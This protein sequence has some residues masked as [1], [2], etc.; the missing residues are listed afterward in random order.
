M[1]QFS[2][3]RSKCDSYRNMPGGQIL[4]N[5]TTVCRLSPRH[6]H[7]RALSILLIACIIQII[8]NTLVLEFG[9]Q[10]NPFLA[11]VCLSP[12]DFYVEYSY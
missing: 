10:L 4:Q 12:R 1:K 3:D 5:A 8:A 2:I 11:S 9:L 6:L 7:V